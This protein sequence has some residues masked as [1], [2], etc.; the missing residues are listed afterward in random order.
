[1]IRRDATTSLLLECTVE[2]VPPVAFIEIRRRSQEG[3]VRVL[4]MAPGSSRRL[5]LQHTLQNL[6]VNDSAVYV[7]V[8]NN[9][10]GLKKQNFTLVVQGNDSSNWHMLLHN[11]SVITNG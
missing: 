10:V 2:A 9:S 8:A 3:D 5:T 11:K 1:M 6:M 7:C 4:N